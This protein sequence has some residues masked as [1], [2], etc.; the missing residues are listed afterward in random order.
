MCHTVRSS[1]LAIK[2]AQSPHLTLY[3]PSTAIGRTYPPNDIFQP[4]FVRFHAGIEV[5]GLTGFR[6]LMD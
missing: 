6:V 2:R 1:V 4:C 5:N 3:S